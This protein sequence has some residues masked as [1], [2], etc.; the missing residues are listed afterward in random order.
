M[1]PIDNTKP[2]DESKFPRKW[3]ETLKFTKHACQELGF[4]MGTQGDF[5]AAVQLFIHLL[6]EPPAAPPRSG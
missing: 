5:P 3:E 6:A 1:E 2:T 4:S